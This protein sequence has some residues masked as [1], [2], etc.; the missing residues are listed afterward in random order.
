MKVF[1]HAL[2][3]GLQIRACLHGQSQLQNGASSYRGIFM[4][5]LDFKIDQENRAGIH[6]R[7]GL[8]VQFFGN[9]IK[10]SLFTCENH[11]KFECGFLKA[12]RLE[13]DFSIAVQHLQET[14]LG[15]EMHVLGFQVLINLF[16]GGA[17]GVNVGLVCGWSR[18]FD[19]RVGAIGVN[20]E[21]LFTRK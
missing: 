16:I 13:F 21:S 20:I 19:G 5:V 7:T 2:K 12:L 15:V 11:I 3:L 18:D 6:G 1:H 14:I 17:K 9:N 4:V 10:A 8:I